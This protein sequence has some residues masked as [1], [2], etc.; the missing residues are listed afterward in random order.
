MSSSRSSNKGKA[1]AD[2]S[3]SKRGLPQPRPSELHPSGLKMQQDLG[4]DL[5]R[6]LV[7]SDL[8]DANRPPSIA[9][10][11]EAYTEERMLSEAV[12][13]IRE[14]VADTMKLMRNN[15][16]TTRCKACVIQGRW[17]V[18]PSFKEKA[19]SSEGGVVGKR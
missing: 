18:E 17:L 3:P 7:Q 9:G 12:V 1:R 16:P 13:L 14:V 15:G 6:L 2:Q 11:A 4:R 10:Q 5:A 8:V 19:E